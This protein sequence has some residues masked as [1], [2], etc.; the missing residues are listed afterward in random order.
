MLSVT[1]KISSIDYEGTLQKLFPAAREKLRT[2]ASKD[3]IVRLF[4]KLDGDALP[5]LTGVASRLPEETKNEFFIRGLGAHAPALKEKLNE[6]L[7]RDPWGRCFTVGTLSAAGGREGILLDIGQIEV[8]YRALLKN[9]SVDDFIEKRLGV[10]SSLAKAAAGAAASIAGGTVERA[11]LA[12]LQREKNKN[13][14]MELVRSALLKYGIQ[15][16]VEEIQILQETRPAGDY[17][18]AAQPFAMTG[19]MEEDIIEALAGYLR[20]SAAGGLAHGT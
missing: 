17:V 14:L 11:G 18:E 20:D 12:M 6:E 13:R 3:M 19:K 8:D 2:A 9:E 15:I 7:H 1:I 10:F 4:Q 5:V 16:E